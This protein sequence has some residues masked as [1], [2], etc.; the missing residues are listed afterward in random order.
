MII[1]IIIIIIYKMDIYFD[2]LSEDTITIILSYINPNFMVVD[3][4]NKC[5]KHDIYRLATIERYP[6]FR[7]YSSEFNSES[8]FRWEDIYYES[9][10]STADKTSGVLEIIMN[11]TNFHEVIQLLKI[12]FMKPDLNKDE[13][14]IDKL[15]SNFFYTKN[16]YRISYIMR[17]ELTPSLKE[18]IFK[19]LLYSDYIT[20]FNIYLDYYKPDD[21]FYKENYNNISSI[22]HPMRHNI[23][24]IKILREG[25]GKYGNNLREYIY[26]RSTK[27]FMIIKTGQVINKDIKMYLSLYD[28]FIIDINLIIYFKIINIDRTNNIINVC[29]LTEK[30]IS[31]GKD[32]GYFI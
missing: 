3:S 10:I 16:L 14:T 4:I 5:S 25:F 17:Q 2:L 8:K 23:Y 29:D 20:L 11:T 15:I 24:E 12:Y 7:K 9:I 28:E 1:I 18:T 30:D 22:S 6:V 13:E 21:I 19:R 26:F 31:I 27:H 32:K